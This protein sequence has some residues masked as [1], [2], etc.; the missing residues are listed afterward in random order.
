MSIINGIRTIN[1]LL[2]GSMSGAQLQTHLATGSNLAGWI[3]ALNSPSQFKAVAESST[4]MNS[5]AA[6]SNAMT[7][8]AAS[9]NAMTAVV[10][11][12]VA[13]MALF[14]SDTALAIIA[15][16]VTALTTM[17]AAAQYSVLASNSAA[18]SSARTLAGT[19]PTASYIVL[20]VSTNISNIGMTM[21]LATLRPGST[22][23]TTNVTA[24]N[25]V[26][27]ATALGPLVMPMVSPF[28]ITSGDGITQ[29]GYVGALRCDV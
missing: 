8:V 23:P 10:A 5:V 3:Q 27:L 21:T 29:I 4:A 17:R 15:A 7:A 9:S 26:S 14:N 20:G 6:S 11:S 16:Y 19:T 25:N 24:A 13:K 18:G 12:S 1:N 28:T 22:R 2:A